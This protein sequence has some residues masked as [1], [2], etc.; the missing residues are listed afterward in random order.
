M[1]EPRAGDPKAVDP[2]LVRRE[3]VRRWSAMGKR[4]GYA[5]FAIAIVVFVIG[6]LGRFTPAITRVVVACLTVGSVLLVPS[7]IFA[8]GVRAAD[9][10]DP[11]T[12]RR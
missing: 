2:V 7:I 6:A 1:G 3:H 10:E 4:I 9:R 11:K 12:A 5:L 8:Y